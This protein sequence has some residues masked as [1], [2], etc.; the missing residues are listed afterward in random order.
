M[1]LCCVYIETDKFD[2]VVSFY[3][4]VFQTKGNIYT[5]NRWIEF[6][7]GNK[8]SIYN[9]L[10][11][12]EKIKNNTTPVNY[13]EQYVNNFPSLKERNVNNIITLN[14]YTSNLKQEYNRI[15]KLTLC[16]VSEIVYVNITEPYYYFNI[17]DPEGNTIEICGDYIDE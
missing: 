3:E 4:K 13:N 6:D 5:K 10:Y 12:V 11:D 15:K 1:E 9:R 7:F 14:F 17:Y 16:E 2:E 8:L